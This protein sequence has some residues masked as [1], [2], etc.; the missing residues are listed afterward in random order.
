MEGDAGLEALVTL[1]RA[2]VMTGP[3]TLARAVQGRSEVVGLGAYVYGLA[4]DRYLDCGARAPLLGHRHP[5][6]VS[7]VVQQMVTHPVGTGGLLDPV[8]VEAAR[9]LAGIAPEGLHRVC[10]TTTAEEA[11]RIAAATAYRLGK[12]RKV[13]LGDDPAGLG[14][15]DLAAVETTLA[16]APG[17]TCVMVEPPALADQEGLLRLRA[18]CDKNEALL[19]L[20][21]TT[22]GLGRCGRMWAAQTSPDLLLVGEGLG[23]GVLPVAAVMAA[24]SVD[25]GSGLPPGCAPAAHAAARATIRILLEGGIPQRAAELGTRLLQRLQRCSAEHPELLQDIQGSGLVLTI[26]FRDFGLPDRFAELMLDRGVIVGPSGAD[27]I[28]L[29]P[30]ACLDMHGVEQIVT[31]VTDVLAHLAEHGVRQ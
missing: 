27:G 18:A 3:A 12:R 9:A 21:E 23:G 14:L 25:A 2:H 1:A 5:D 20:D 31:A 10:F 4:G 7:A 26:R 29:T 8:G 17:R 28:R 16:S 22:T 30:P 6:V 15:G 13:V 24:T 19:V 11:R